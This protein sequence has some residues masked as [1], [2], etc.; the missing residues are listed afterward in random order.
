MFS[1][2]IRKYSDIVQQLVDYEKLEIEIKQLT[3]YN[4]MTLRELFAMGYT[5]EPPRA[6]T[7][8][9]L[10]DLAEDDVYPSCFGRYYDSFFK[11]CEDGDAG[12]CN[13]CRECQQADPTY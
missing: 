8:S 6:V 5:L 11:A 4:F 10:A 2:I 12:L 7:S 1:D 3:G 13:Y 9:A